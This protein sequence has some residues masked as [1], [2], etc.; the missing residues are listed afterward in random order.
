MEY[1]LAATRLVEPVSTVLLA[2]PPVRVTRTD[3]GKEDPDFRSRRKIP[4]QVNAPPTSVDWL[5]VSCTPSL[6]AASNLILWRSVQLPE[7]DKSRMGVPQAA[8]PEPE[9]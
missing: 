7:S 3:T 4:A 8:Q 5:K 1:H 9:Q 2:I 6:M